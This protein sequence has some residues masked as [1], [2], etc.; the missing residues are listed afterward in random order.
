M[1]AALLIFVGGLLFRLSTPRQLHGYGKL[2][3]LVL[4][5]IGVFWLLEALVMALVS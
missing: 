2:L 4:C 5:A 3:G 1:T